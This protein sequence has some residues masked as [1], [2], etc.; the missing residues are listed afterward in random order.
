MFSSTLSFLEKVRPSERFSPLE[1]SLSSPQTLPGAALDY[2]LS[3]ASPG[4]RRALGPPRAFLP[5]WKHSCATIC[6]SVE[7][8]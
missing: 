6:P 5:T 4:Q 2:P 8:Q 1:N 3:D 7:R